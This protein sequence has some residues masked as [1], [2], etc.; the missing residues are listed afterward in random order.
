M[1]GRRD[2]GTRGRGYEGAIE[3]SLVL[4]FLSTIRRLA[5]MPDYAAHLEHLRRCHP[6]CRIPS[7]RQYYEEFIRARYTDGP[8]RCC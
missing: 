7:E 5:G 8:N 4:S 1:L 3:R 6:E 2:A